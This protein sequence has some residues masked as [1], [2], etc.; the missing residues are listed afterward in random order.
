MN[1]GLQ[2]NEPFKTDQV[3]NRSAFQD[4]IMG[5]RLHLVD[6]E[7]IFVIVLFLQGVATSLIQNVVVR[8]EKISLTTIAVEEYHKFSISEYLDLR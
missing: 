6:D 1:L 8:P 2:S 3:R 7:T 4:G 5:T